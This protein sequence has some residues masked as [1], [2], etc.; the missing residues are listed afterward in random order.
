MSDEMKNTDKQAVDAPEADMQAAKADTDAASSPS[1]KKRKKG[2]VIGVI[3]V[4]IALAGVGFWE[5]HETPGFC[6][7]IC[8]NMD[9]YLDTYSEPGDQ[10]GHDKY[11]NPVSNTNAMMATLH[12]TNETTG[13]SDFRC[14][15]CHHPIIGEQVSEAVGFVSGNYYDPLDERVGDDLTHWWGEPANKFCVNENCHSYLRDEN[16]DVNYDKLEAS[17]VWMDFNPHSQHHEDIR[18]DCTDCHK[19]HRASVQQC[20]GCHEDVNLPDGWLTKTEGDKVIADEFNTSQV[21]K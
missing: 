12:R 7:A 4:V 2:I 11:G 21:H 20:T 15:T 9:Q 5:W 16:G 19:G 14:M 6:A 17:T 1:L 18:M 10:P 8:H 3:A 13:K